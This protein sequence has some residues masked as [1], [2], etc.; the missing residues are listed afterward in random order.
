[1]LIFMC[2]HTFLLIFLFNSSVLL[3]P[4]LYVI[5]ARMKRVIWS[6][7]FHDFFY[8]LVP[9]SHLLYIYIIYIYSKYVCKFWSF[10]IFERYCGYISIVSLAGLCYEITSWFSRR[11]DRHAM[12]C[13]Y[14]VSMLALRQLCIKIGATCQI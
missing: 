9:V 7:S 2:F 13:G 1:L 14:A 12:S 4:F 5:E 10:L 6:L 8:D 3:S 11:R